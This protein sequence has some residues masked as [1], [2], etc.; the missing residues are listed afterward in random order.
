[1]FRKDDVQMQE[2]GNK[3]TRGVEDIFFKTDLR[4]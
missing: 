1:V 4:K 3:R 2:R